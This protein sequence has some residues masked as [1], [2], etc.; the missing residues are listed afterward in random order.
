M[1]HAVKIK[2]AIIQRTIVNV[3][4]YVYTHLYRYLLLMHFH[5]KLKKSSKEEAT[6]AGA[7]DCF[8][9]PRFDCTGA[10]AALPL[11]P[12]YNR[13]KSSAGAAAEERPPS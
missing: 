4:F 10:A 9:A 2:T 12:E 7:G 11:P 13:A 3:F 8:T 6:G 5:P 1:H